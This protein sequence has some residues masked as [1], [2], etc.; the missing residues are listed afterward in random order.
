MSRAEPEAFLISAP[1]RDII[2]FDC[3]ETI[4]CFEIRVSGVVQIFQFG[5]LHGDDICWALQKHM[6]NLIEECLL[7]GKE[8]KVKLDKLKKQEDYL[9]QALV[10]QQRRAEALDDADVA[11]MLEL[12]EKMIKAKVESRRVRD[13][14][15]DILKD[16]TMRRDNALSKL[17]ELAEANHG[18]EILLPVEGCSK[19]R[20]FQ[21]LSLTGGPLEFKVSGFF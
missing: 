5:T 3:T 14:L 9:W 1:L 20:L 13:N 11:E 19:R 12:K 8:W 15:K 10:K 17:E 7:E 6:Y 4:V 18:V 2:W 16:L 21:V